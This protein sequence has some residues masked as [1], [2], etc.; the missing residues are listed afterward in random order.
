MGRDRS[1]K[2]RLI[3]AIL[4][5]FIG[6]PIEGRVILDIG[7]GN[8]GISEHFAGR[9]EVHSV[10]V[11]D[12]RWHGDGEFSFY[13]VDSEHLPFDDGT[14]DIVLSHHVI[15]HVSDQV[16]HLEEIR[17]TLREGGICYLATPNKTSPILKG[18]VGNAQVLPYSEMAR[19]FERTG[20]RHHE[21][22]SRVVTRPDEFPGEF[23]QGRYLPHFI[24]HLLRRYFPSHFFILESPI[25]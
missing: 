17:R 10:D 25:V 5:D 23:S 18:H 15:E 21:Y 9:N 14:F 2:G 22:S 13:L 1:S 7:C 12:Q 3:E 4:T 6:E 24:A 8:G 11:S 16:L 20:W 19:L